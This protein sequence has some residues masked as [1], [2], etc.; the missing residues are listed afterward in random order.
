MAE[1]KQLCDKCMG[2]IYEIRSDVYIGYCDDRG[3][4]FVAEVDE[5]GN[6]ERLRA[7]KMPKNQYWVH[8]DEITHLLS[9]GPKGLN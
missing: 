2:K 3:K 1:R 9:S 7:T 5:E 8:R 4:A 6:I